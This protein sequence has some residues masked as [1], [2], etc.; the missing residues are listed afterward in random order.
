MLGLPLGRLDVMNLIR[1][2]ESAN[3]FWFAAE[4]DRTASMQVTGQT[5]PLR[6]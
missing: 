6:Y 1:M 2:A 4:G 5:K 3:D